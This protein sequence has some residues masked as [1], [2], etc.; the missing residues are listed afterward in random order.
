MDKKLFAGLVV[1]LVLTGC[2]GSSNNSGSSYLWGVNAIPNEGNVSIV[3]NGTPVLTGG[4]YNITS[5]AWVTAAAGSGSLV[6]ITNSSNTQLASLTYTLTSNE[7]YIIYAYGNTNTQEVMIVPQALLPPATGLGRLIFANA[8]ALQPSVDVYVGPTGTA[9]T[10]ATKVASSVTAL[11]SGGAAHYDLAP[12]SYDVWYLTA[13]A[14]Q[15]STP[16]VDFNAAGTSITVVSTGSTQIQSLAIGDSQTGA[17]SAQ[18]PL[19]V[20]AASASTSSPLDAQTAHSVLSP[21]F[22]TK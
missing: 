22:R 3:G 19:A 12:G 4:G 7:Y 15:T 5:S 11:S 14:P 21:V 13:G 1:G 9:L 2:G 8:S 18:Q 10:A 6:Y 17:T 16:L 20:V